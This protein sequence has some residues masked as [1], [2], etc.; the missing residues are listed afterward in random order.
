ML[1]HTWLSQENMQTYIGEVTHKFFRQI[2]VFLKN[3]LKIRKYGFVKTL[4]VILP[5]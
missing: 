3:F 2:H 5:V 4:R 1:I